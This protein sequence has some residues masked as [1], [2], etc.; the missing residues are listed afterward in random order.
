MYLEYNVGSLLLTQT[1]LRESSS[2]QPLVKA[3][4]LFLGALHVRR[5][6]RTYARLGQISLQLQEL[7]RAEEM[8]KSAIA[9]DTA[10]PRVYLWLADLLSQQKRPVEA[11]TCLL[12]LLEL[13]PLEMRA[14]EE[15]DA[16]YTELGSTF[17]DKTDQAGIPYGEARPGQSLDVTLSLPS[18][19]PRWLKVFYFDQPDRVLEILI[20]GQPV[21]EIYGTGGG[22]KAQRFL[23][24]SS[25][26]DDANVDLVNASS[27]SAFALTEI[28]LEYVSNIEVFSDVTD[29]TWTSQPYKGI[30][31]NEEY[32]TLLYNPTQGSRVVA[33]SFF[34]MA[35]WNLIVEVD[36][37]EV[38]R[39]I[40]GSR[41]EHAWLYGMPPFFSFPVPENAGGLLKVSLVNPSGVGVAVHGV[42]V[43]G[44]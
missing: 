37:T 34:D 36:N 25:V 9:L 11:I 43:K 19:R 16:L 29:A 6:E 18:T 24:P 5:D 30:G 33:V 26:N 17:T 27:D 28:R 42:Y 21:G 31:S 41:R 2:L 15:L 7:S 4:H 39:I 44:R 10:D 3:K 13:E 40:G 14:L 32:E 20:N 12:E 8:L 38:G 23:V 1:L 22:W 35:G